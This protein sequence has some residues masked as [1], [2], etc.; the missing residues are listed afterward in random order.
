MSDMNL[1]APL[2]SLQ[3]VE[4]SRLH[5][6]DYNP[7]KVSEDNLKLL[8]QSI[9]T[10]GWTLP[11]V[12]R[13][14]Y[15]IID[16]FHRWTVSGREPLKTKLGGK[17][18]VVIVDHHG[19]NDEDVYGTI[20]HNR[21]R[22]THLLEPMKAIVKKLLDEGKTVNEIGKQLGMKPEE[23]FRLSGFNR[24]DFLALMTKGHETYSKAVIYTHL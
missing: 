23:V 14:D 2:S 8:T 13:P 9:L 5:A 6:N 20:T 10:N 24:E 11:I 16:G 19:N 3:W 7:N 12:V 1:F 4:R 18:P 15:T 21:A 17:V 22:G